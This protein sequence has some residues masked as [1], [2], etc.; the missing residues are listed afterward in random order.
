M[1]NTLQEKLLLY[2][3]RAKRDPEAFGKIYDAYVKRIYRFVYFKVQSAEEAQDITSET[4][5]KLW[6]YLIDGK[7]VEHV[8]ALLYQ[9]S[10]NAIV[11]NVRK[12]RPESSI[13]A[14]DGLAQMPD[15][16]GLANIYRS[17]ELSQVLTAVKLLKDEYREVLTMR[18]IDGISPTEIAALVG[19]KPG[20]VR[21]L[22][23][24]ALETVR[25]LLTSPKA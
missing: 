13:D 12:R 17:A 11:D 3:I 4:F 14:V 15:V 16:S 19:K 21:V 2:R 7:K 9:I 22:L 6:Q 1:S 24:R 10:R 18:Y 25:V 20:H 5:L 23:H 8:G